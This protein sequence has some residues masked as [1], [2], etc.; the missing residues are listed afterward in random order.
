MAEG[1]EDAQ[2][3]GVAEADASYD[4][5]GWDAA[6]KAAALA[7]VLMDAHLTPLDVDRRGIGRLTPEKLHRAEG[8][9][10]NGAPGHRA[11]GSTPNGI[12]LRG[13]RRSTGRYRTSWRAFTEP[14]ISCCSIPT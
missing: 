9:V 4:I 6:A 10:E 13:P 11:T 1:I 14:R 12:K 2:R 5:D 3:I 7:N 8:P